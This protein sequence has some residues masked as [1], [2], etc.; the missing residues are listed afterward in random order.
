MEYYK[1]TKPVEYTDLEHFQ[2]P[3]RRIGVIVHIVDANGKI[4]LQQRGTKSRDENGLYE[5]VGGSVEEYDNDYRSAISREMIEEMG[6]NV[7]IELSESTGIYHCKK[8]NTNWVFVIFHGKY[9]GGEIQIMEP[10]KCM[11]YHFFEYEE[12]M[13]SPLV[14]ESCKFLMKQLKNYR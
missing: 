11:G 13:F 14:S 10:T 9:I 7:Q 5:D 8:G 1:M 2:Y 3:N 6:P 12:A 4:L